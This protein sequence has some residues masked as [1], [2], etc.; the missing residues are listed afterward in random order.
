MS[1]PQSKSTT[2]LI[3][4]SFVA[5]AGAM[6]L[7]GIVAPVAMKGGLSLRDAAASTLQQGE[8]AIEPLDLPKVQAQL[9]QAHQNLETTR[10][11]TDIAMDRLER[12]SGR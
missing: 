6:T 4:A 12:L 3:V 8:P 9:T 7:A 1:S 5:G 2:R 11:A 10:A